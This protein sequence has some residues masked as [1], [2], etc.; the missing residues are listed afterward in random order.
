LKLS[1][2]ILFFLCLFAIQGYS[3]KAT[4][5]PERVR[6]FDQQKISE[7][8]NKKEFHYDKKTPPINPTFWERLQRWFWGK[9]Y[10]STDTDREQQIWKWSIY[11]FCTIV[12]IYIILRLTN[13]NISGWVYGASSKINTDF[14]E[15]TENIHLIDFDKLIEE[16][17]KKE[18]YNQAIRL[19]YLKSLKLLNEKKLISIEKDKT[20]QEYIYEIKNQHLKTAFKNI[21]WLFE[22]VCYGDFN[23]DKTNFPETESSFLEFYRQ[24]EK[25]A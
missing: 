24:I 6:H 20:N 19:S 13:T 23:I 4:L 21:T 7:Y 12:V 5:K 8:R 22:Y 14:S 15:I 16:A 9:L 25:S 2:I 17:K 1:T 11:T 3:Q 10:E 18:Q